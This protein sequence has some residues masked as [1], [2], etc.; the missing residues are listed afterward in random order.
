MKR[1]EVGGLVVTDDA[2]KLIGM[3][4][5]RDLAAGPQRQHTGARCD[6]AL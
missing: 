5:Q 6:D 1:R 4:T 2:N 3:I